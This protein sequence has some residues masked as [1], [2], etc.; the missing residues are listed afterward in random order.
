[1]CNHSYGRDGSRLDQQ[2][3]GG[4]DNR[5]KTDDVQGA[6]DIE[7][8]ISRAGEGF[9]LEAHLRDFTSWKD[10]NVPCRLSVS[11]LRAV[12]CTAHKL[13][14][15][16]RSSIQATSYANSDQ[17]KEN[18]GTERVDVARARNLAKLRTKAGGDQRAE[19]PDGDK[20]Q[21]EGCGRTTCYTAGQ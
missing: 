19:E 5:H 9:V 21:P 6:D 18:E 14:G 2:G 20:E 16:S 15:R 10:F 8:D 11:Q 3:D 12:S 4:S 1:M 7:D 13:K 17:Q